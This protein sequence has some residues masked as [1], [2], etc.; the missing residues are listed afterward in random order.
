MVAGGTTNSSQWRPA[1]PRPPPN[2]R[3][4]G[5]RRRCESSPG[6]LLSLSVTRARMATVVAWNGAARELTPL[7]PASNEGSEDDGGGVDPEQ[8]E[9]SPGPLHSRPTTRARRATAAVQ[10]QSGMRAHRGPSTSGRRWGVRVPRATVAAWIWSDNDFG[11]GEIGLFRRWEGGDGGL[12]PEL[13]AFLS[14]FN[15]VSRVSS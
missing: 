5:R 1:A 7:L 6:P 9:S 12:Q 11:G 8:R 15:W 10:I 2:R 3:L 4:G 14:F 13:P